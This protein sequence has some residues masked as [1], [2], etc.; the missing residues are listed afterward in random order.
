M[1]M[2]AQLEAVV[3]KAFGILV[4]SSV[5]YPR[6]RSLPCVPARLLNAASPSASQILDTAKV[7]QRAQE[8]STLRLA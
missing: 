4:T 8:G 3:M 7:L 5:E 6:R 1:S 2:S